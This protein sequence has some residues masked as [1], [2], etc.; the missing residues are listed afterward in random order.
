MIVYVDTSALVKRYVR[1]V[2]TDDVISLLDQAEAIG[3]TVLTHVEMASALEKAIHLK[4][5]ERDAVLQSWQDFLVHWPF[6]TRLNI[7]PPLVERASR[8]SLEHGLRAYDAVQFA[9]AL[10][11]QETLDTPITL[12]TFD[13][14]LWEAG[15]KERLLVWPDNLVS[16]S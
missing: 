13:H 6:L 7:N 10:V 14:D 9:S 8:L 2:G 12:A 4:W 16:H 1:E 11:W 5:V 3:T 15:K